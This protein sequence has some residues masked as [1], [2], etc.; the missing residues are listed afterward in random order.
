MF[1]LLTRDKAFHLNKVLCSLILLEYL[2]DDYILHSMQVT[3]LL[4]LIVLV[5]PVMRL[6]LT[7]PLPLTLA[8]LKQARCR[9]LTALQ[10]I[11]VY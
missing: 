9:V 7:L 6:S 2:I 11:I 3:A 5:K 4:S 10:N 8:K 1:S